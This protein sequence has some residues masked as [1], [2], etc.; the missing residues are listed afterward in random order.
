MAALFVPASAR[1]EQV[2]QRLGGTLTAPAAGDPEAIALR[3]VR[4]ALP[5][6]DLST[7]EAPTS[8]TAGGVTMLRWRQ[9]VDGIPAADAELRVNVT[10]DGRVLS[11]LG[12]PAGRLRA[13]TTPALSA[14]EAVRAVQDDVGVFR[15]LPRAHGPA[16]ATRRTT[17][18][19]GTTAAL[20]LLRGRLS[21]RVTYRA[22]S[23]EVWDMFVDGD[24]GKVL[25]RANLVKSVSGLVWENYPGATLG[26]AAA[27]VVLDPWLSSTTQLLGPNVNAYADVNDT[28]AGLETV[29]G[30]YAFS[31]FALGGAC[32]DQKQCS[33]DP[34]VATSWMT[35]RK[36]NAVQ[37][38]YFANRFHD[39]LKAAPISFT[40]RA[41]EGADRLQLETD[42]SAANGPDANYDNA[43]MYTPPDGTSPVMQMYLWGSDSRY[44][45]VNGGD[46]ASILYH[47]YTHGL[48]NRLIRDAG[49]AG[50]LNSA[51]AGAM[52]EGWSDW[53]AKDF[54]VGQF[55]GLDNPGVAGDV[56]MGTYTD[57]ASNAIRTQGLDCP[58]SPPAAQCPGRG[59]AGAG[60]YTYG[61]FGKILGS[62]EV[63]YDGEI[64]AET[65]W[66]LRSLIGSTAAERLITQGMRLSPA[67]PTF[68]DERNAILAADQAA[69]GTFT[70]RIWTVFA[71]RGMGYY[72][73][74]TGSDDVAPVEDFSPPP[75]LAEPR[76]A[77]AGRI[78]DTSGAPLADAKVALGSLVAE[79]DAD[80]RYALPS[81]PERTY[82]NLIV[83]A[84]GHDRALTPVSVA[85]NQTTTL[86]R[87]LRR[88]WAAQSGGASSAGGDE[89]APQGCGSLAAIDQNPGLVDP[90]AGG[91]QGDGRDAA[92]DDRRRPLR[93][94][95]G[96]GL[97]RR[98]GRLGA[99]RAHRDLAGRRGVDGRG[100]ADV[101]HH[102]PAGRDAD[103]C[104]ERRALR[105]GDD[106]GDA[107]DQLAVH[108]HER[109]RGLHHRR[110]AHAHPDADA[111][112]LSDSEPGPDADRTARRD[113]HADAH[114]AGASGV[115][116]RGLRQALDPR[117]RALL[118]G[119]QG[120]RHA[121]GRRGDGPQ[122]R[123]QAHARDGQAHVEGGLD[124][125][126][127]QGVQ[128]GAVHEAR[129][130]QSHADRP[131]R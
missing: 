119:V 100:R 126:H 72:A 113:P 111:D 39:H 76:G 16:G 10:A 22:S 123:R 115:H 101:R 19:D 35:N 36:Q 110:R 32:S 74:T 114:P 70:D 56:H 79:A 9:A 73:S 103:G 97:R 34:S 15:S 27:P 30:S 33:W 131:F 64:W 26:G 53:Y 66:D 78:T 93:G 118:A 3:Y 54:L 122:A 83:T 25:K 18:D 4:Q 75:G 91:R 127:G 87:A 81:V 104:R 6:V 77:I 95:P 121:D 60:G 107:H 117:G 31:T 12:A 90:Q 47:E 67:E 43:N 112:G 86:D 65:L 102:R 14:G 17:Y 105:A 96:R 94:R 44:R 84:P 13:D 57:A 61:D 82:A 41:F 59:A 50:A 69:G 68:L 8:T 55:G 37:A 7:L 63:H 38:F 62:P 45:A 42:D 1:A 109:V 49:G 120:H 116:H 92:G 128:E 58:V 89:L 46:D 71:A 85:A 80:G 125:V 129:E 28:S 108:G 106:P 2:L 5:Q 99:H 52:G 98:D 88:N 20:A 11:V 24:T 21:W 48:S 23:A 29:P 130:N 40:D 124:H 51:Q